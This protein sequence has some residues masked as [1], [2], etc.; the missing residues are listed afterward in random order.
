MADLDDLFGKTNKQNQTT[1]TTTTKPNMYLAVSQM[2]STMVVHYG[3]RSAHR[4]CTGAHSDRKVLVIIYLRREW[5]E[6]E[7]METSAVIST[8]VSVDVKASECFSCVSSFRS[9]LSRE[10]VLESSS[11][12]SV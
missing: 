12:V 7:E 3:H 4:C 9:T 8:G 2:H 10:S 5:K 6:M 11:R 1:K